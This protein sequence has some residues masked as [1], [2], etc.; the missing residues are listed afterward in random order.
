MC[1]MNNSES[2]NFPHRK[3]SDLSFD[4]I[5]PK[6]F[7]TISNQR[8]ESNLKQDEDEHICSAQSIGGR[9]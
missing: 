2:P 7:Q 3:N 4:A 8:M 9:A 1:A 6:C 5:C